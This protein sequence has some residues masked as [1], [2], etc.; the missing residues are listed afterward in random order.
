[1]NSVDKPLSDILHLGTVPNSQTCTLNITLD[2]SQL[3][4]QT[5]YLIELSECAS[6]SS[7]KDIKE[8]HSHLEVPIPVT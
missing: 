1:M 4:S 5:C 8:I 2:D 6:A 3:D 7:C